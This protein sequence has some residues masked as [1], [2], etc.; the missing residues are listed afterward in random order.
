MVLSIRSS[1]EVDEGR[2][3]QRYYQ[4]SLHQLDVRV[5]HWQDLRVLFWKK[6]LM[7]LEI[8]ES[9]GE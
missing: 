8:H 4:L 5:N 1:A 9:L 7:I 3:R 2:R 6:E